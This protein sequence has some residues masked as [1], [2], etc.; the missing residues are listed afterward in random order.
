MLT[1][2]LVYAQHDRHIHIYAAFPVVVVVGLPFVPGS[3]QETTRRDLSKP[4]GQMQEI[5]KRKRTS[6]SAAG[7]DTARG[8]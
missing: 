2:M 1:E 8:R 7:L 3:S 6:G 5:K 4:S